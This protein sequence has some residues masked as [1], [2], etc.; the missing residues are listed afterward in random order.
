MSMLLVPQIAAAAWRVPVLLFVCFALHVIS[1][2]VSLILFKCGGL[3]IFA[4]FTA[5]SPPGGEDG[6]FFDS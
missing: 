2:G 5:R 1:F 6:G 3:V 4:C